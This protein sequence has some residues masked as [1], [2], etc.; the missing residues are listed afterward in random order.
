M[1]LIEKSYEPWRKHRW[2][3]YYR[4]LAFGEN[5]VTYEIWTDDIPTAVYK[6]DFTPVRFIPWFRSKTFITYRGYAIS[7]EAGMSMLCTGLSYSFLIVHIGH[8]NADNVLIVRIFFLRGRRY[9]IV[10]PGIFRRIHVN[11]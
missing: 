5:L 8:V 7:L 6:S 3:V 4:F 9:L 10:G 1:N 2:D 11:E